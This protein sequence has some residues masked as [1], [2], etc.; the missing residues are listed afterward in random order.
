MIKLRVTH[1]LCII[2][3]ASVC[4]FALTDSQTAMLLCF[5]ATFLV[6]LLNGPKNWIPKKTM[7][8]A[9]LIGIALGFVSYFVFY[10]INQW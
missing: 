6:G 1:Y 4:W 10:F 2:S 3:G 9:F 7:V 5:F 8:G